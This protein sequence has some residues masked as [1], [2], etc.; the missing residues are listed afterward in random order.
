[1]M[2]PKTTF[3]GKNV[4]CF[5]RSLS[6][7]RTPVPSVRSHP[8]RL[9]EHVTT[10]APPIATSSHWRG[11]CRKKSTGPKPLGRADGG[12]QGTQRAVGQGFVPPSA[13]SPW[14][15]AR[16]QA[17]D[18]PISGKGGVQRNLV[19][20]SYPFEED[21]ARRADTSAPQSFIA[22]S[23]HRALPSHPIPRTRDP[24]HRHH[25]S[26]HIR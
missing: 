20:A 16:R 1:M 6:R 2:T 25:E 8:L 14:L 11:Q 10:L 18:R 17:I 21:P 22:R 24:R 7:P 5:R 4:L 26:R 19:R 12:A 15:R 13:A 3:T 9:G 23:A